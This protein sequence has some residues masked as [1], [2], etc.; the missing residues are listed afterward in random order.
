MITPIGQR[1]VHQTS[2]MEG[3]R[4]AQEFN[5]QVQRELGRKRAADERMAEAQEAVPEIA[6]AGAMRTEERQAR[7]DQHPAQPPTRPEDGGAGEAEP[8][9]GGSAETAEKHL[10]FLI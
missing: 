3:H 5:E 2:Q 7:R 8:E 1:Q 10:D 6:K 9:S 4:Q